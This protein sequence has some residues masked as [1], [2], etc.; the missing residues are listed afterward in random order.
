[1]TNKPGRTSAISRY[2]SILFSSLFLLFLSFSQPHRVHHVFETQAQTEHQAH[3]GSENDHHPEDAP[4]PIE[5]ECLVLTIAQNSYLGQVDSVGFTLVFS[6]VQATHLQSIPSIERF[7][8]TSF[9]Q[10]AP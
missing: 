7:T 8:L 5:S 9:F 4:Q 2:A 6:S 1:M 10:R 3:P